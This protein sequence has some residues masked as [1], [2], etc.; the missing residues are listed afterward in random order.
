MIIKYMNKKG[1]S[2]IELVIVIAAFTLVLSSVSSLT[3]ER[4][5]TDTLTA[6]SREVVDIIEQ[7]RNY[8]MSGYYGDKWSISLV[9]SDS[10]CD[11]VERMGCIV[12]F[13]GSDWINRDSTYDRIVKLNNGIYISEEDKDVFSFNKISGWLY[14]DSASFSLLSDLGDSKE[15]VIEKTGLVYY[16]N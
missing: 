11:E 3:V 5:Y 16:T 7:A 9:P 6:K 12:L 2:A 4:T 15:V 1:F 14:N 8:S 13:K 10:Y